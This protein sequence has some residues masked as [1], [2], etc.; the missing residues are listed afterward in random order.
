MLVVYYFHGFGSSYDLAS[1]KVKAIREVLTLT[2]GDP[3]RTGPTLAPFPRQTFHYHKD[4]FLDEVA[5]VKRELEGF[6]PGEVLFIGTS[7]GGFMAQYFARLY[8]QSCVLFN[9]SYRPSETLLK[10]VDVDMPYH[11]KPGEKIHLGMRHVQVFSEMERE[12][13]G[14]PIQPEKMKV[15]LGSEDDVIDPVK[16]EAFFR[17]CGVVPV[18]YEDDHRFSRCFRGVIEGL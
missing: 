16:S 11:A 1:D 4:S 5:S 13:S 7:L 12:L 6:D 18:V 3:G 15:F 10:Y 14:H 2:G 8:N 17:E 9:P